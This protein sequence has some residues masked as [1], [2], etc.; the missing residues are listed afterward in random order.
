MG[1]CHFFVCLVFLTAENCL[2]PTPSDS[3]ESMDQ[4]A[5]PLPLPCDPGCP[6]R[7]PHFLSHSDWSRGIHMTQAWTISALWSNCHR[8]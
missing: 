7:I 2:S 4:R 6:I 5:L 1:I 8:C 3:L